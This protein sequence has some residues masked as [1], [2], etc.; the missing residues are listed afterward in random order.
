MSLIEN[1]SLKQTLF[2]LTN[3]PLQQNHFSIKTHSFQKKYDFLR[4][5]FRL[6]GRDD[7]LRKMFWSI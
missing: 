6:R 2:P 1:N 3:Y 5:F 4:T 7:F